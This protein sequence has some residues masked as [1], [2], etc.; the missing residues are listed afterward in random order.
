MG[1]ID[2]HLQEVDNFLGDLSQNNN[3]LLTL[4]SHVSLH[5]NDYMEA[6][7]RIFNSLANRINFYPS[8]DEFFVYSVPNDDLIMAAN[9]ENVYDESMIEKQIHKMVTNDAAFYQ[10]DRWY[11]WKGNG[12]FY[13]FHLIKVE[14]VYVGAWVNANKFMTPFHSLNA[15]SSG[16]EFLTTERFEPMNNADFVKQHHIQLQNI[17]QSKSYLITGTDST[18]GNFKLILA[19]PERNILDQLPYLRTVLV[20]FALFS[21]LF[22][23]YFFVHMRRVFIVP[24]HRL[25]KAME[26]LRAGQM[27]LQIQHH[28]TS[29]EFQIMN[30]SFNRMSSEIQHLTVD[31]YEEKLRSQQAELKH[32]QLQINPHF[33][34]N[35]LNIIYSLAT[36]KDFSLIQ[37]MTKCLVEYF[38][39]MF[40]SNSPFVFIKDELHHTEN[41]LRIQQLRFPELLFY[42]I[43]VSLGLQQVEI[44]PL[45]VQSMVENSIKYGMNYDSHTEINISI[46]KINHDFVHIIIQD[47][48]DG[49]PQDVL[50]GLKQKEDGQFEDEHHIGIWNSIKRLRCLYGQKATISFYNHVVKGAVV[51]MLIPASGKS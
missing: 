5:Y 32:L 48:G 31:V 24:I 1:Q 29:T 33:F 17:G 12:E 38:R 19:I 50:D 9:G 20:V 21:C 44:P 42:N 40:R 2:Q 39:F 8:M 14:N 51:E 26:R 10:N 43:D 41:Y 7:I 18:E 6:K 16:Y 36:V 37:E 45:L 35:S 27:G 23:A 11:S 25:L 34:L 28:Q 3:D 4:Q 30:E 13:L 49:F 22:L 46:K 15:E 47:N